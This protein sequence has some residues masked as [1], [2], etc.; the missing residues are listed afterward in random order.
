MDHTWWPKPRQGRAVNHGVTVHLHHNSIEILLNLP[1]VF[2]TGKAR[3]ALN[4]IKQLG[5][6]H[7]TIF[8]KVTGSEL[9]KLMG[10]LV[11]EMR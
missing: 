2:V 9:Q 6:D 8:S 4:R 3:M 11:L 7:S 10:D 1:P 5:L